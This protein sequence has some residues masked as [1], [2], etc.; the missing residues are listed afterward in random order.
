MAISTVTDPNY[1][2]M[3]VCTATVPTVTGPPTAW[4]SEKVSLG[5]KEAATDLEVDAEAGACANV[6][7]IMERRL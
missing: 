1:C 7:D 2:T 4:K 6:E 3:I 5:P